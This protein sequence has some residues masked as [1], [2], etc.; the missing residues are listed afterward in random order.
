MKPTMNRKTIIGAAAAV[1]TAAAAAGVAVSATA[2]GGKQK[3][4][5]SGASM[6]TD[7]VQRGDLSDS[8]S[9]QGTLGYGG[10]HKLKAGAGGTVT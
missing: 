1:V 10:E 2:D 6:S 8:T 5:G 9:A 7:P 3:Q 4:R